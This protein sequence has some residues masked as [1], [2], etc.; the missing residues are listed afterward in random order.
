MKRISCLLLLVTVLAVCLLLP[1]QV[2]AASTEDGLHYSVSDGQVT[3]TYCTASGDLVIPAKIEGYPVTRIASGAFGQMT[4]VTSVTLPNT[5][6]TVDAGAFFLCQNLTKI[7]IPAS[8][9]EIKGL[10]YQAC[11]NLKTVTVAKNNPNYCAD[12]KGTLY[13][14]DKTRL[15]AVLPGTS[16][17]FTIPG[18]V[19]TIGTGAFS[20]CIR[21][22]SVVI[23]KSVKT[24]ESGAFNG[25]GLKSVT[26]PASVTSIE[27][28]AFADCQA[29]TAIK[30]ASGNTKYSSDSRGVLFNKN[31]TELIGAPGGLSGSYKLPHTVEVIKGMAFFGCYELTSV[32]IGNG[33]R[34]I[35]YASFDETGVTK[36]SYTGTK[37]QWNQ[38]EM[39]EDNYWLQYEVTLKTGVSPISVTAQPTGKY[40]AAGQNA[41][42]TVKAKGTGITYQ[43]Q[44]RTSAKASWKNTTATGSKTA[45]VTIS[46][47]ASKSGYQ[48]RC[49]LTDKNGNVLYTNSAKLVVFRVKTQPTDRYVPAGSTA[50]FTVKA[51]GNGLKY[52]WQYRSSAKGSWKSATAAGSKTATLNVPVTASK[53]GFYYRC[54]ITD[55]NGNVIYSNA[56]SLKVITFK[57]TA[58][59]ASVTLEV[60]KTAVF[61]VTAKGTGLKYQWQYRTSATASWKKAAATGNKTAT[62]KVPVTASK[63]GF[64]YRCVI[65]D[66]YGNT[67]A[68]KAASLVVLSTS[69]DS[70]LE[71]PMIPG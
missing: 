20:A 4:D 49:R 28:M 11:M 42:F 39:D 33:V 7:H 26:I 58:Q 10:P 56:A 30:V 43:W 27:E 14:K 68:S 63:N 23:P 12:S 53:N 36:V 41:K 9:T 17:T 2:S 55:K 19:K 38:I 25:C 69:F 13:N 16:G 54:K 52:Q 46:A 6:K 62:L 67:V 32:T 66:Q 61:Q 15:I 44:Y 45:T 60:G 29:L 24:I 3:I 59:P 71:L 40:A 48:Y 34:V 35:E 57:L 65:T 70:P 64:Q 31:K 18:T 37:A 47:T 8:V 51:E 22:T 5:V 1:N 21:M 50:K